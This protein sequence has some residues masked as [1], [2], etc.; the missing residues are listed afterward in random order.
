[1]TV[2][3][4]TD[5]TGVAVITTTKV[6]YFE[7]GGVQYTWEDAM[8]AL[9]NGDT[10]TV[11]GPVDLVLEIDTDK[12]FTLVSNEFVLP[13]IVVT[14]GN[15]TMQN[16]K[17]TAADAV[18]GLNIAEGATV[19][20]GTGC[21]ITATATSYDGIVNLGT[22]T[23]NGA[24]VSTAGGSDAIDNKG[25]LNFLSGSSSTSAGGDALFSQ[26]ADFTLTLGE[27]T[28][29]STGS[30][31]ALNC[32]ND[33]VL[34]GTTLNAGAGTGCAL[35][36]Q[37]SSFGLINN[38][39]ATGT[40]LTNSSDLT[41]KNGTFST[42]TYSHATCANAVVFINSAGTI[43]IEGG[44]FSNVG[45]VAPD[46][47]TD[48]GAASSSVI[49]DNDGNGNIVITGGTFTLTGEGAA[50]F[51]RN[52]KTFS[53][54]NATINTDAIGIYAGR[55]GQSAATVTNTT[56]N[57]GEVGIWYGIAKA[58]TVTD[59]TIKDCATAILTTYNAASLTVDGGKIATGETGVVLQN[60]KDG[61]IPVF[62][63]VMFID[64]NETTSTVF[65]D[66]TATLT[67]CIV[68]S[69]IG[70]EIGAGTEAS[71]T[72]QAP[73]VKYNTVRYYVWMVRDG[74]AAGDIDGAGVRV[75]A[76]QEGIRFTGYATV[77]ADAEYGILIAPVDYVTAAGA[78][79]KDALDKWAADNDV[80]VAYQM[81][82]AENSLEIV[83]ETA[84]FS[85]ALINIKAGNYTRGFAAVAYV[86]VG[87]DIS[88]SDYDSQSNVRSMA[89]V[90]EAALADEMDAADVDAGY[91][92]L[93]EET[94]KYSK[95]TLD[96]R[97]VLKGYV[98]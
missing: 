35:K 71:V 15:V 78:F 7:I 82:K 14:A 67:D 26:S 59:S 4:L 75:T 63:N 20:L 70:K 69:A 28:L 25:V 91:I 48:V 50:I 39:T 27:I 19:T 37:S 18:V 86:K 96:Q 81:V 84:T 16:V 85:V 83:G 72:D 93:N 6:K 80:A 34:N 8:A 23:I 97:T 1:V 13:G 24:T 77:V 66:T 87:E 11:V 58:M 44:T 41:I 62:E 89:Q 3:T 56:I 2:D 68:L 79:T 94:G 46:F 55:G 29:T 60:S 53:I 49:C 74:A 22:L 95:Y 38:A 12:S 51:L 76:G 43:T 30:G 40:L 92:Y 9:K 98:A 33:V 61:F 21:V 57:G 17:I 73:T 65:G 45:T 52:Y 31:S 42:G 88:Y 32:H 36:V 90:A 64:Q 10:V 5:P 47:A 54:S